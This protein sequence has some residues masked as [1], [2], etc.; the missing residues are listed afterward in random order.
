MAHF[1]T[2]PSLP[3]CSLSVLFSL[4]PVCQGARTLEPTNANRSCRIKIFRL[5]S[6][7]AH[8][9]FHHVTHFLP[10]K[11]RTF[12]PYCLQCLLRRFPK[13]HVFFLFYF[14]KKRVLMRIEPSYTDWL[15]LGECQGSKKGGK[16][17]KKCR[18]TEILFSDPP[19]FEWLGRKQSQQE[20]WAKNCRFLSQT[21]SSPENP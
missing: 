11:M 7:G 6:Q 14:N 2:M 10:L 13:K 12:A 20:R 21:Q 16:N 8:T 4:L 3:L 9:L 15:P 5:A 18:I 19:P 17:I 1:Q